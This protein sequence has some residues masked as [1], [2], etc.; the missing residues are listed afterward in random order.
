MT[1]TEKEKAHGN[2]I[3]F[4]SNRMQ[5]ASNKTK[6]EVSTRMFDRGLFTMN[7][8]M[9]IWNMPHIEDGD[10]RFVRREYVTVENLDKELEGDEPIAD[11]EIEGVSEPEPIA[12]D[13]G[14]GEEA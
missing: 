7:Q 2:N 12:T 11:S 9:D 6:L 5:Y 3:M 10:K 13:N 4:S 8:V 14:A 1:F